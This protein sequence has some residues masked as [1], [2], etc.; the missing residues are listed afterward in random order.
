MKSKRTRALE[1][2]RETKKRVYERDGGCCIWCGSPEGQ[3]NA[4][5][6]PR[7]RGG[8]G[9]EQNILTLCWPCHMAY[10][11]TYDRPRMGAYFRDYLKSKYDEWSEDALYYKNL[12]AK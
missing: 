9:I 6:I 8:L 2:N 11:Q 4:H 10:D 5:Y 1:I 7:S 12:E 3:P